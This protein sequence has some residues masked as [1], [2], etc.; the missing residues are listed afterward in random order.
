MAQLSG[1]VS[2]VAAYHHGEAS[3]QSTIVNMA[4]NFVGSN[5]INLLHPQ[6]Q[7]GTRL[8][9]GKDAASARYIHTFL[10]SMARL[11]FSPL[12][13][14]ILS[15]LQEDGMGI[16]PEWYMPVVPLVLLNGNKGI[17]T[18]WSSN[19]PNYNPRD[20]VDNLRRLMAGDEPEPMHPW[21]RGF[22][23]SIDYQ[24]KQQYKISGTWS[25]VNDTTL[26][27]TELPVG[28]WTQSF[29]VSSSRFLLLY[30]HRDRFSWKR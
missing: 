22:Q 13:D 7:F 9:G 17:G 15:Y 23:G 21:Y 24:G 16:E 14:D 6:G 19:I 8:E 2:E 11:V 27:V 28:K 4:Q 25:R 3:L 1:Y 18:G 10:S 5:N 12:D 20:V 29:K 30:A 26:D